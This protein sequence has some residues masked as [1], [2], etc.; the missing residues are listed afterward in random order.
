[1]EALSIVYRGIL[2]ETTVPKQQQALF[3]SQYRIRL[4]MMGLDRTDSTQLRAMIDKLNQAISNYRATGQRV[5][6]DN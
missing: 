4:Y 5:P 2:Q 6:S 3:S 1:M